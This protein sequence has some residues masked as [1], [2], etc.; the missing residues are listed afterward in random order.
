[1]FFSS[2]TTTHHDKLPEIHRTIDYGRKKRHA[3]F[4]RIRSS[5]RQCSDLSRFVFG[6][7][8]MLVLCC[9]VLCCLV[10]SCLVLV[11]SCPCRVLSCRAVSCLALACFALSLLALARL[12]SLYGLVMHVNTYTRIPLHVGRRKQ[13][14]HTPDKSSSWMEKSCSIQRPWMLAAW[15]TSAWRRTRPS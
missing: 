4:A 12:V 1:M 8:F 5:C 13:E 6:L 15:S 10:L 3:L 14:S 9:L 11:L 7:V 2:S